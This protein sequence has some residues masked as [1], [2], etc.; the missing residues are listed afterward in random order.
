MA[1]SGSSGMPAWRNP[2]LP[3]TMVRARWGVNSP[4]VDGDLD[5]HDRRHHRLHARQHVGEPADLR[6]DLLV[7][8]LHDRGVQPHARHHQEVGVLHV[9]AADLDQVD[10]AVL[11][12]RATSI[13]ARR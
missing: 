2:T 8:A 13:A 12:V 7:D 1:A 3:M 6:L 4:L 11:A 10:R 9:V 5:P